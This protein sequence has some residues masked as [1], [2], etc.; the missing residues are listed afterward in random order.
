MKHLKNILDVCCG[1]RMM[2]FDKN[3][4]NTIYM[5]QRIERAG[6]IP[7]R[8]NREV[9]PDIVA[10]FRFLPFEDERF[11]LVVMDPPHIHSAGDLFR[12][13]MTFGKL[14]KQTWAYDI[15][16]GVEEVFRVLKTNGIL[17]FKWNETQIKK[18]SV[19]KAIGKTPL[20]GHPVLSKVP[21][22]WFVFMKLA[23]R[24]I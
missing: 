15:R 22:H 10:D 24:S 1:P 2:W 11:Q 7:E 5:D 21:T 4:E 18:K 14:N 17:I 9:V 13:T 23:K 8:P 16:K 6:F 12:M 19:L 20:F 3:H